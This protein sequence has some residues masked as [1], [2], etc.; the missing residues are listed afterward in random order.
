MAFVRDLLRD[1]KARDAADIAHQVVAVASSSSKDKADKF[2]TANGIPAPCAA[3]ATYEELVA[4]PNVDVVYVAT[5]HSHH[6]QNV[7]L[8]LE[9]GKNVLCEKAFTV[10]AAQTKILCETARKKNLF[11]ME[12]V[13]TRYFP[14]S[15]QVRQLIQNGEIGEV[16]RTTADTSFGDDV[17]ERWG[18]THRMVNPDLAGGCLLDLGIYS[19]TW[20]FQTLYHTLPKDQRKAPTVVSQMTPYHAT[21]ADESTTILL[22]FPT[23]TPSNGPHPKHSHGVAMTN[24][25][26]AADPDEKGTTG[27]NIRIQ[28][29]KGEIQVFGNPF[30]PMRYRI[31][32]K[33]GAGEVRDVEF[34]IPSEGHGMF[35]EAD[36]VARCLRD[37]KLESE[38]LPWEESIV[39]MEV[40]DEVRKQGGL[41]YPQKIESTEYPLQL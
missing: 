8:V 2:I 38:G 30:R 23:S 20:V 3:Y 33:K 36:E 19:L 13:W 14:L 34:P 37:G 7:M 11:L 16:L 5:P 40:M 1:P 17:E 39:I 9:A 25:R 15:V 22:N 10:N 6:F 24:L 29:T 21:G 31:I 12:A 4:D 35:W 32:P 41:T 26:V 28:G 18:T 27:A